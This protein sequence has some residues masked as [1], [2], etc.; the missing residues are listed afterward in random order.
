MR[1]IDKGVLTLT[2]QRLVFSGEKRTLNIDLAKII[3][4]Q[5][6]KDGI[7][8]RREGKEK[9][10]YFSVINPKMISIK[11]KV[12]DGEYEEPFTGTIL[13]CLIE[14]AIKQQAQL[15]PP[16]KAKLKSTSTDGKSISDLIREL[17]DLRDAG[18]LTSEEFESKKAEL[19]KRI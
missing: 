3:S 11:M 18:I 2:N 10:Q 6:F 16:E 8:I 19:L 12:G 7:A 13:K 9:T 15:P 17:A 4:I 5:P 1:N 14:G